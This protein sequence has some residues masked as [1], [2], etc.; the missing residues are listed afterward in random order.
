MNT[1][2]MFI[3]KDFYNSIA[4]KRVVFSSLMLACFPAILVLISQ[5]SWIPLQYVLHIGV[6]TV[7]LLSSEIIFYLSAG[8][9]SSGIYDIVRLSPVGLPTFVLYKLIFPVIVTALI[10]VLSIIFMG[11]AISIANIDVI[12]QFS[13]MNFVLFLGIILLGSI[14]ELIQLICRASWNVKAHTLFMCPVIFVGG[15]LCYVMVQGYAMTALLL[16]LLL[17]IALLLILC[18]ATGSLTFS[19]KK[20]LSLSAY[21]KVFPEKK[22]GANS[23]LMRKEYAFLLKNL[24]HFLGLIA[25]SSLLLAT[26]QE[27][28]SSASSLNLISVIFAGFP[29]L[30]FTKQID[31][32]QVE[33]SIRI[34]ELYQLARANRFQVFIC[35]VIAQLSIS[36]ICQT[37]LLLLLLFFK[38]PVPSNFIGIILLATTASTVVCTAILLVT[39]QF[40]GK[41]KNENIVK[42]LFSCVFFMTFLIFAT[43]FTL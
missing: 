11:M 24:Y 26:L 6:L 40:S 10:M 42:S 22:I 32:L 21:T 8:E 35:K 17:N 4:S 37:V 33:C 31:L 25:V 27:H 36:A 20:P 3:K 15:S 19:A 34:I 2:W 30:L 39:E 7:T 16:I 41:I 13:V 38:I 1:M 14:V 29:A 18:K 43:L 12:M 28:M 23:A 5:E 9:I